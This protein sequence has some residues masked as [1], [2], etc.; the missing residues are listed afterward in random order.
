MSNVNAESRSAYP[1]DWPM[2]QLRTPDW[3]RQRS[4]FG[5]RAG[6][7]WSFGRARDDLLDELGRLGAQD[8]ILSTNVSLRLDGLAYA[9][10]REP[11][12]PG[13][14]VWFQRRLGKQPQ[15]FV[16]ACDT[17]DRIADNFRAIFHTIDSLR[18]IERHGST[19]M[20]EQAFTGFAALPPAQTGLRPWRD[21]LGISDPDV[22]LE[23]SEKRYRGLLRTTHP[24]KGGTDHEMAELNDA[25]R[26]ARDELGDA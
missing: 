12:D 13:V 10:Q 24:D 6:R 4:R 22:S 17:Y 3:K 20:L 14:A 7:R 18:R 2:G 21:V 1:L 23:F 9:N 15:P 5:G 26:R 25:I 16:I 19:N 8:V 11:K